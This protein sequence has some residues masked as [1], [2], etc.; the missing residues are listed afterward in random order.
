[1]PVRR[2]NIPSSEPKK[3]R[4]RPAT[5]PE[6]RESRLV[7]LA[8]GVAE[9]QMENGTVSAQVLT[10]YL[11]LG[12]SRERL[13]QQRLSG[14]VDLQKAKIEALASHKRMEVLYENA[15]KAFKGYRGEKSEEPE[16]E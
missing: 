5:T 10:H 11:K 8:E 7:S 3:P 14:E 4:R 1:M 9:E 2:Q 6:A 15:M 13:E 12:S 16:D